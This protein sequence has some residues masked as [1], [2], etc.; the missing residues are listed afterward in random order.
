M[1]I[2][3]VSSLFPEYIQET[4]STNSGVKENDQAL[5]FKDIA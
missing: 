4:S 1:G 2:N 3:N 5:L